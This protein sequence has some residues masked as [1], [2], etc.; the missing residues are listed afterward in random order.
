MTTQNEYFPQ[1]VFHPGETLSEKLSEIGISE[2]ELNFLTGEKAKAINAILRG[3]RSIT[4]E[5]ALILESITKIPAH[6]WLKK[7]KRYNEYKS[8]LKKYVL[9]R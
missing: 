1:E 7:Q 8:S 3:N 4:Q 2:N 5:I 6:F 9:T